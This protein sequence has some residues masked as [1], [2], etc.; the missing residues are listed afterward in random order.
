MSRTSVSP[1]FQVG[2][3]VWREHTFRD[4][5]TFGKVVKVHWGGAPSWAYD[6]LVD[7]EVEPMVPEAKL[8]PCPLCPECGE[9]AMIGG[10]RG[11]EC[12]GKSMLA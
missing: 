7:G 8:R 6:L 4:R 9:E 1:A 5:S 3:G 12:R 11:A 2:D 10:G